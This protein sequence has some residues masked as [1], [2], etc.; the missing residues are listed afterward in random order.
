MRIK[1]KKTLAM[2]MAVVMS[3][4]MTPTAA[5]A[6]GSTAGDTAPLQVEDLG[7]PGT[8]FVPGEVIVGV[9]GGVEALQAETQQ[10]GL[11]GLLSAGN[12]AAGVSFTVGETL[13]TVS[14]A[15]VAETL[16]AADD[17]EGEASLLDA[18][19]EDILQ[20]TGADTETLV[21]A[22]NTLDCVDF[23]QPNYYY[24]LVDD[25]A[26]AA[27]PATDEAL[28]ETL[29]AAQ[30]AAAQATPAA[31]TADATPASADDPT[32]EPFYKYQWALNNTID[33]A[34]YNVSMNVEAA[35]DA[36]AGED[37]MD[38]PV[39]V[40][41]IDT[42]VDYTHEDLKDNMWNE[43]LD[44][45]ELVALGG[46]QYGFNAVG[47]QAQPSTDPMDT[48]IG[49]GTHCASIIA[50][51]WN[52]VGVAGIN[53][54]AEIMAV[55]F[56]GDG[57]SSASAIKCFNYVSAAKDAGVN[58]VATNNS[59]GPNS[60][61]ESEDLAL[62]AA[63]T[64]LGEKGVIS[65]FSA[66]NESS[67]VDLSP[68]CAHPSQYAVTV[69]AL[70]SA[71]QSVSFS[72]Y[73]R[74]TVDVY[75][76]GS[77]ILA[78]TSIQPTVTDMK[79]QYIPWATDVKADGTLDTDRTLFMDTFETGTTNTATYDLYAVN[80]QT[81]EY[82]LLSRNAGTPAAG[83]Y[84]SDMRMEFPLKDIAAA[85]GGD[86]MT[87]GSTFAICV[88]I[89]R[90]VVEKLQSSLIN[91]VC[92]AYI[93]GVSGLPNG[94]TMRLDTYV[95]YSGWKEFDSSGM[96]S[97]DGN[98][99]NE[100]VR[101]DSQDFFQG[102][103]ADGSYSYMLRGTL[104]SGWENATVYIDD[105]ALG[106]EH[107]LYYYSDGTSMSCPNA[108]GVVSLL[109]A[110]AAGEGKL[111]GETAG[112][113]ALEIIAYLKGTTAM[114][115]SLAAACSTQGVVDAG[116]AY[117]AYKNKDTSSVNPVID[118]ITSNGD[119][120]ATVKGHFFGADY[121]GTLAMMTP[122]STARQPLVVTAWNDTSITFNLP[123][124]T[125]RTVVLYVATSHGTNA[126]R[127]IEMPAGARGYTALGAP[128]I[129]IDT[130][131]GGY[132]TLY[133]RCVRMAATNTS[134]FYLGQFDN[135]ESSCFL[136]RY[137]IEKAEWSQ[138]DLPEEITFEA[139][140]ESWQ[141]MTGS[142]DYL[143][144]LMTTSSSDVSS[145][146]WL[147]TYD[148][149]NDA[150]KHTVKLNVPASQADSS[151]ANGVLAFQSGQLWASGTG[152]DG[153]GLVNIY[154]D[155]GKVF[156]TMAKT[157]S[158]AFAGTLTATDLGLVLTGSTAGFTVLTDSQTSG[159]Y[160][161]QDPFSYD[162][163]NNK[164]TA[165]NLQFFPSL[166]KASAYLDGGQSYWHAVGALKDGIIITG[167]TRDAG[168]DTMVD[169]WIYDDVKDTFTP[170]VDVLFSTTHMRSL[171]GCTDFSDKY[172]VM[173][174]D[175]ISGQLVFKVLDLS[176]YGFSSY[177]A[178]GNAVEESHTHQ[179]G[180]WQVQTE[181]TCAKAGTQTRD[182]GVCG[183]SETQA[184]PLA[185]H[186]WADWTIIEKARPDHMGLQERTCTA[187]GAVVTRTVEFKP[188]PDVTDQSA[189]YFNSVYDAVDLGIFSG[190]T[191]GLFGP[192]DQ[193]TRAQASVV[194]WRYFAPDEAKSYDATKAVDTTGMSDMANGQFYTGA[195]NWAVQNKVI[196][197]Y[198]DGRFGPNDPLTREQLC[199]IVANAAKQLKGASISSD[200]A[201]FDALPDHEDV[202]LWAM[203]GVAWGLDKGII[204]GVDRDGVRYLEPLTKVDRSTMAAIMVNAINNGVFN[205]Q[206]AQ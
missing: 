116:K 184:L 72:N 46:G 105:V 162:T 111:T 55:R 4:C 197:G 47:N 30:A 84:F 192:A 32:E 191:N 99:F 203:V 44:Y 78:A 97:R 119:G 16:G 42:G 62:E 63:I 41:V 21:A 129:L 115:N 81:Q 68:A 158:A 134:V 122:G 157:P 112:A 73:G 94:T 11:F 3:F 69:G 174:S 167:P 206:S 75:A 39:V 117:E 58:V 199:V 165:V 103:N 92:F 19:Q 17:A 163:K 194:L 56:I 22:L 114:Q 126:Y 193:L 127:T 201:K 141:S 65:V 96:N 27:T 50:S 169:T 45:P 130:P 123:G 170:F 164:W 148:V 23:A 159:A 28:A 128:D 185:N 110:Y 143:Y 132:S 178:K 190:Y 66:G 74:Q 82:T 85:P 9:R 175:P 133:S 98:W 86:T 7:E 93:G 149:A 57:S 37:S 100:S 67:N 34:G 118:S 29:A 40:A 1:L 59:Y 181:S 150:W 104:P 147:L 6:A 173:A 168:K 2:F 179:W 139:A 15:V 160:L 87:E 204:S 24:Q 54:N 10:T 188:F 109:A 131:L 152:N 101:M 183:C 80:A 151:I 161:R 8:D 113:D 31:A 25:A 88:T 38:D 135:A 182:C 198:E 48:T 142:E 36:G 202:D 70:N 124:G 189:W 137:D 52:D 155:T 71:D 91:Q 95:R 14:A 205:D 53:G 26:A 51:S 187:C 146:T 43:G 20:V 60:P 176:N 121:E 106:T 200:F 89:P 108:T 195:A 5:F 35:W 172:Y 102:I 186:S 140:G 83:G 138:V 145:T 13:T 153:T 49:H 171:A 64:A 76:P 180:E 77:R 125:D 177:V 196:N 12:E 90:T 79:P 120:T 154:P 144:L 61:L 107:S 136:L 166:Q 156:G 33:M 18:T